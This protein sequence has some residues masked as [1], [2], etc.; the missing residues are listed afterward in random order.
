[1]TKEMKAKEQAIKIWEW[2]RNNP[3]DEIEIK[4]N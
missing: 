4:K 2:M 1:M 3:I